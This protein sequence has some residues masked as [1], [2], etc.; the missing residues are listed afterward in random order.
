MSRRSTA[1][2]YT[3]ANADWGCTANTAPHQSLDR[4]DR[5]CTVAASGE[6]LLEV[7]D[8]EHVPTQDQLLLVLGHTGEVAGDRF[9]RLGE[10]GVEVR[11]VR[12]PQHLVHADQVAAAYAGNI[13]LESGVHLATPIVGRVPLELGEAWGESPGVPLQPLQVVRDPADVVLD[14]DELQ[15]RMPLKHGA[16]DHFGDR[17]EGRHRQH[18]AV[19][20][21]IGAHLW[22]ALAGEDVDIDGEVVLFDD[23]P[24]LLPHRVVVAA[25]REWVVGDEDAAEAHL[26]DTM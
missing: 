7:V 11:V 23:S 24:E 26:L 25:F 22:P 2:W 8:P 4:R 16:R 3:K 9:A 10:G 21:R 12:A 19:H 6:H 17:L 5:C 15:M 1:K 14:R 20:D 13:V 18:D